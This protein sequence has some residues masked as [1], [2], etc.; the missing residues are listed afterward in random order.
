MQKDSSTKKKQA[1]FALIL[2]KNGRVLLQQRSDDPH[3][4]NSGKISLFGGAIENNEKPLNGLKREL[5]EELQ[6][7]IDECK[8]EKLNVYQKTKELDGVDHCINV[9]LVRNVDQAA[10]ALHEGNA[11][12]SSKLE[13]IMHEK[14]LTRITKL[15][16]Q[17]LLDKIEQEHSSLAPPEV[18]LRRE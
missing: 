15:A 1:A 2:A 11:I 8:L 13:H 7:D 4:E 5:L 3:I 16:L 6:L 18:K 9:W 12:V 17:D 10:L 14:K